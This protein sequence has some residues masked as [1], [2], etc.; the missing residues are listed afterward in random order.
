VAERALRDL[1]ADVVARLGRTDRDALI[2]ALK[3]LIDR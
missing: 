2:A 3:G 1:D